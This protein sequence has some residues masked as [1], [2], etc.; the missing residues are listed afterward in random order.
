MKETQKLIDEMY[1]GNR[2]TILNSISC[3]T[4]L[5]VMNAIMAGM[6]TGMKDPAFVEGVRK[7]AEND[8]VL[9]G[10]PICKVAAAAL[11]LLGVKQDAGTDRMIRELIE[12]RFRGI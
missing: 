5:L 7:A 10:V 4:P 3:E 8:T 9:L 11:H 12:S 2:E 6:K 1:A